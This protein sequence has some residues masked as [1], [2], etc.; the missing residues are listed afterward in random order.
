MEWII[1]LLGAFYVLGGLL[2]LRSARME[3]L[4]NRA[5]EKITLKPES[6]RWRVAFP[7]ISGVVYLLAGVTLTGLS[8]WG[9]WLLG[10]GLFAQAVYYPLA[11]RMADAEERDNAARWQAARNAGVFSAAAFA[12]AA[13]A[14]R[15]GV[16]A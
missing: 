15:T 9:V 16:I 13:Y 1:R 3:W 11:W 5:I 4:L 12:L 8:A 6:D 10:A 2:L 7:V 14:Y